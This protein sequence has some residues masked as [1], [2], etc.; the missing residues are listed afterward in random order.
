M[1]SPAPLT[2]PETPRFIPP[3]PEVANQRAL[4]HLESHHEATTRQ[5]AKVMGITHLDAA[6]LLNALL[7]QGKLHNRTD[8]T[9]NRQLWRLPSFTF[10]PELVDHDLKP[11]ITEA[12][13]GRRD[14]I[15]NLT[16]WLRAPKETVQN[17]CHAMLAAGELHSSAVGELLILSLIPRDQHQQFSE[18]APAR[19]APLLASP[20]ASPDPLKPESPSRPITAEMERHIRAA[21]PPERRR[22]KG[23]TARIARQ[24]GVSIKQV[25]RL[26]RLIPVNNA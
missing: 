5:L 23:E 26:L 19:P 20:A 25:C 2:F 18:P 7:L 8:Y 12:L 6:R 14:T 17:T 10:K 22:I 4:K 24:Y 13:F 16:H 3:T 21:L 11:R 15:S 1:T 9:K